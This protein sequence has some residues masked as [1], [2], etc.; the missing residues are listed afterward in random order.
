MK[1]NVTQLEGNNEPVNCVLGNYFLELELGNYK[2]EEAS[3]TSDIQ[4]NLLQFLRDGKI[5][6]NIVELVS[7]VVS[8]SNAVGVEKFW[9]LYFYGSKNLEG[10]GNGYGLMDPK[11]NNKYLL[12]YRLEFEC[13][14]NTTEYKALVQGL[15]KE[16]ELKLKNLKCL[17][18]LK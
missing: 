2:A 1:H 12:S 8:S 13:T 10:L 17:E 6:C 14:N 9:I 4:P 15:K 11:K 7:Y 5:D 16:M 18:I 3:N